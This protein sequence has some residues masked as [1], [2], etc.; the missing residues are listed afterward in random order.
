MEGNWL[1]DASARGGY[2]RC[3]REPLPDIERCERPFRRLG[4]IAGHVVE[5]RAAGAVE[6]HL[7]GAQGLDAAPG[8]LHERLLRHPVPVEGHLAADRDRLALGLGEHAPA[9]A[10]EVATRAD[11]LEVDAD[12]DVP[13][14]RDQRPPGR[15][16]DVEAHARAAVV[17]PRLAVRARGEG[18]LLGYAPELA[19]EE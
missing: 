5:A 15:V 8:R 6:E 11:L 18:D 7:E 4:R 16:R 17:E 13:R 19:R 1:M 2:D 3:G 9:D 12:L 14:D 10:L